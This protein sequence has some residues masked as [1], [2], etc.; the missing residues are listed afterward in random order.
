MYYQEPQDIASASLLLHSTNILPL[1][2]ESQQ[3]ATDAVAQ[4]VGQGVAADNVT[5]VAQVRPTQMPADR[6][7]PL[8]LC[9]HAAAYSTQRLPTCLLRRLPDC[10]ATA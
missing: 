6:L 9:R 1:T 3:K 8:L 7:I 2:P 10:L 4:A 5:V